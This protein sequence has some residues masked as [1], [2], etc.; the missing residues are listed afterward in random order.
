MTQMVRD[1]PPV[2]RQSRTV[3]GI[4]CIARHK[5]P[6]WDLLTLCGFPTAVRPSLVILARTL[7]VTLRSIG[8]VWVDD[9]KPEF[10][11]FCTRVCSGA[12]GET[13]RPYDF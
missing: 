3:L 4:L 5:I 12:S 7:A 11:T 10:Y 2:E 1:R 8:L 9:S 13:I 6:G